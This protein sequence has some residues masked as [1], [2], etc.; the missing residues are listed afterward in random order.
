MPRSIAIGVLCRGWVEALCAEDG[1][2]RTSDVDDKDGSGD[3]DD[4]VVHGHRG[5]LAW[6]VDGK[7]DGDD[8][9]ASIVP[10]VV[11][12]R[13]TILVMLPSIQSGSGSGGKT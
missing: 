12:H 6:E 10:M 7:D 11:M 1:S 8:G 3:K 9:R 13:R 5:A 4:G 2:S